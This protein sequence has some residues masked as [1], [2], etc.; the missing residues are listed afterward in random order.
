ASVGVALGCS[1]NSEAAQQ[2]ARADTL[3][4]A[5]RYPEVLAATNQVLARDA[6]DPKANRLA[7]FAYLETGQFAQAYDRL[8]RGQAR[9]PDDPQLLADLARL[10]LVVGKAQEAHDIA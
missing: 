8:L 6:R 3:A 10:Y 7:G 2:L 1:G 5:G 9:T 4:R